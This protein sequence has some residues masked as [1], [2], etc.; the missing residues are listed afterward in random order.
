MALP[1][2]PKK[3]SFVSAS[4]R[5]RSSS[6]T[7]APVALSAATKKNLAAYLASTGVG[8]SNPGVPQYLRKPKAKSGVSGS[9]VGLGSKS[10]LAKTSIFNE[11]PKG[12]VKRLKDP[13][14]WKM[15]IEGAYGISDKN[16][17]GA[18]AALAAM[19]FIP[20]PGLRNI[21]KVAAGAGKVAATG[22]KAAATTSRAASAVSKGAKPA[23]KL[24]KAEA[25][26]LELA[27][28][29]RLMMPDPRPAR[30]AA[31][32]SADDGIRQ[33]MRGKSGKPLTTGPKPVRANYKTNATFKNAMKRWESKLE[34]NRAAVR[35]GGDSLPA[36]PKATPAAKKPAVK[37]DAPAAVVKKPA[38]KKPSVKKPAAVKE[39]AP[40]TDLVRVPLK[41]GQKASGPSVATNNRVP[42]SGGKAPSKE[43]VKD[44]GVP[45]FSY[46][47][48]N[49]TALAKRPVAPKPPR[50]TSGPSVATDNRIPMPGAKVPKGKLSK[51]KKAL[52]GAAGATGLLFAGGEGLK[53]LDKN[54]TSAGSKSIKDIQAAKVAPNSAAGRKA[55]KAFAD[56]NGVLDKYGRK[57]S[58]AEFN[59]REAFRARMESMSPKQAE[60][61][62]KKEMI[63]RK[64]Y[65][66]DA[67]SK[68]FGTSATTKT[69]LVGATRLDD[70]ARAS[71]N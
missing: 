39:T 59:R 4:V 12:A 47:R 28:I 68:R 25:R 37:K 70:R 18:N 63:R 67:G 44:V 53:R 64:N 32:F 61:A 16:S 13:N 9:A 29:K 54:S 46:V 14:E 43:L 41:R 15:A 50:K 62:K 2:K 34:T 24:S 30:A 6:K 10:P 60:A 17:A 56:R 66:E 11:G 20:V 69:R 19:A 55:A 22:A 33:A 40:S 21:G 5:E 42:L 58:R 65:R 49:S 57:V 27:D 35:G 48:P 1:S 52:I 45:S 31:K 51:K 8:S 36:A 3:S 38:V 23:G 71:L 7:I 26:D